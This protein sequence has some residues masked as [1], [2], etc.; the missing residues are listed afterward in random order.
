[1]SGALNRVLDAARRM[2]LGPRR[3]GAG[4][5]C[6]CP[7]HEDADP[8]LSI[9]LGEEGRALVHCHA[10][11]PPEAV[12]AALG[13]DMSQLREQADGVPVTNTPASKP[14]RGVSV[15]GT[16]P[17]FASAD[18]VVA[19]LESRLGTPLQRW[20]YCDA[21]CEMVGGVVRHDPP[22]GKKCIRPFVR[23]GDRWYVQAMETPRPLFRLP[24]L[25]DAAADA[26]VYVVEGEGVV[27]AAVSLGLLAT[28]SAGG[29]KAA[30]QSDWSPVR[31]RRV[32]ILPDN[33]PAG[34]AYAESVA[35]LC[36]AAGA[37][38][39]KIVR[40]V[41][42]WDDL[43]EGG[44]L[45]DVLDSQRG[46]HSKVLADIKSLVESTPPES[47]PPTDDRS[48][49]Y[50]PFPTELLPEPLRAFVVQG[51]GSI[52]CDPSFVALPAL[53]AVAAAIGNRRCLVLS[54]TWREPAV[55]WTGIIGESGTAKSPAIDL[56]LSCVHD[57]QA[58]FLAE[59][60]EASE[61]Y[62]QERDVWEMQQK[63]WKKRGEKDATADAAT[64][65]AS[66]PA[67]PRPPVCQRT[68]VSDTTIEALFP[69]LNDNQGSVLVSRDELAGWIA[70]FD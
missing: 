7:A 42:R 6:R 36:R 67:E 43:G 49:R 68:C 11:C 23:R 30:G 14:R 57:Q 54:D 45:A 22:A 52:G 61:C 41:D 28:T 44:D 51:A 17:G 55:I 60:R 12:V 27:D 8:S 10:G 26:T 48:P 2:G 50:R 58:E 5:A 25:V 15:T 21:A 70:G 46:D 59:F 56:A 1:M 33:D 32:I 40:L 62:Q 63:A 35:Q 34:E 3:S 9:G 69:I 38:E 19:D 31:G 66:R 47:T 64:L 53:S 65:I 37:S 4:W 16:D 20:D 39:V 24:K 29:A 18:A 13:L